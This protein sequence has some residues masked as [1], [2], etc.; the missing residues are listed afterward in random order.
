LPGIVLEADRGVTGN[1]RILCDGEHDGGEVVEEE[2]VVDAV[3]TE[4]VP[5]VTPPV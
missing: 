3:A 2:E 4:V 1:F 5:R